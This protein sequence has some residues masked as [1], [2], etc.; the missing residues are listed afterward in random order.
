MEAF[1]HSKSWEVLAK[2]ELVLQC[3]HSHFGNIFYIH[4][5][6]DM[7]QPCYNKATPIG[8]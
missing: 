2:D 3:I 4:F 8:L 7:S 6:S 5:M 1:R